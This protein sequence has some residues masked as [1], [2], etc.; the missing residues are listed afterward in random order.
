MIL[1]FPGHSIFVVFGDLPPCTA[2]D[3]LNLCPLS[4]MADEK[5]IRSP[6]IIDVDI[7]DEDEKNLKLALQM[8]LREANSNTTVIFS[9][10][11]G[12]II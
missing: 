4:E 11:Q 8:S 5:Y 10:D 12:R 2:D 1:P 6:E 7:S 9:S 3:A